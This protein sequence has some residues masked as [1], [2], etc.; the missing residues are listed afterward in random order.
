MFNL[1]VRQYLDETGVSQ[2]LLRA[3]AILATEKYL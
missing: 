1:T 2:V 3:L